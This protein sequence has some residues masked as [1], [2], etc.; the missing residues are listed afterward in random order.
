MNNG[1]PGMYNKRALIFVASMLWLAAASQIFAQST[2]TIRGRVQDI[3]GAVV[4]DVIVTATQPGTNLSREVR[5][6]GG[7]LYVL[8][9]LPVGNWE[10]KFT[11]SGFAAFLQRGVLLQVNTNVEVN[12]TLGVAESSTKVTVSAEANLV[13]TASTA[14]VQVVD[15]RRVEDLP[16]N[17]RN[18]LQ[19]VTVNAGVADRGATGSTIQTNTLAQGRYQVPASINGSR[20]NGTNYLLDS[21]QNNDNYT[22]ISA[23]FPNPDA[24]QEFS[25]QTSSFDAEYG[26][27]VGGVVNMVTRSGTNAFHGTL[28]EYL[29]NYDLNAANFFSGRDSLK[30]NQF[31][32]SAG[33]PVVIPGLYDGRDRTF[34]FGSYQG[35]RESTPRPGFRL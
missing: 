33:G 25:I 13:Q 35:T 4:P 11:K 12:G 3:S 22:N 28:F 30:R 9:E 29:R 10:V 23:P 2:G 6:D 7:G 1:R 24:V 16:L 20:G 14:L 26:R 17:G 8:A 18:V 21:A 32:F 19:L 27:G 34:L 15:K 5:T 31:G